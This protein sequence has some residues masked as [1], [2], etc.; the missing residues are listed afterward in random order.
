M[1]ER[2]TKLLEAELLRMYDDEQKSSLSDEFKEVLSISPSGPITRQETSIT[3][4]T[5]SERSNPSNNLPQPDESDTK[6]TLTRPGR[7]T[8]VYDE[9]GNQWNSEELERKQKNP[10]RWYIEKQREK[11]TEKGPTQDEQATSAMVN[12]FFFLKLFFIL[13]SFI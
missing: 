12:C 6:S 5:I 9:S 4:K 3:E 11:Q 2:V 8:I 7:N 10:Y 13:N 1:Y